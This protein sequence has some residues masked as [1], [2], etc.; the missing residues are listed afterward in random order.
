[1]FHDPDIA[2]VETK[3]EP[4]EEWRPILLKAVAVL[5]AHGW[6][7][8]KGEIDGRLCMGAA[9]LRAGGR[10]SFHPL[11]SD[12]PVIKALDALDRYLG[13]AH[14]MWNDVAGRTAEEVKAALRAAAEQ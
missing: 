5:D 13:R 11:P 7:Q 10:D 3:T 12:S 6:C 1:M 2:R 9:V 14:W 8:H 4:E